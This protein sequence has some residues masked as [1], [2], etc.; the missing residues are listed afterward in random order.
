MT[1]KLPAE[2]EKFAQMYFAAEALATKSNNGSVFRKVDQKRIALAF[3]TL[4]ESNEVESMDQ[5][6]KDLSKYKQG[7]SYM[8]HYYRLSNFTRKN[9]IKVHLVRGPRPG[10]TLTR[11]PQVIGTI[12]AVF[13]FRATFAEGL[14]RALKTGMSFRTLHDQ[15]SQVLAD[16]AHSIQVTNVTSKLQGLL[17][18][19]GMNR[20]QLAKIVSTL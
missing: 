20:D 1:V 17:R 6:C 14:N 2:V 9:N 19:S 8:G 11:R 15:A 10:S 12:P 4:I 5:L 16:T 3:K 18:E 7:I 13:D